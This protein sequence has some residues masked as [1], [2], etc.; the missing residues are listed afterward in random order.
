MKLW[1]KTT[2]V[3]GF[4]VNFRVDQWLDLPGIKNTTRYFWQQGKDLCKIPQ[5]QRS[6][7][8]EEAVVRL[9]LTPELLNLQ[10][11]RYFSLFLFFIVFA[12]GLLAYTAFLV[13]A[14][15]KMGALVSFSLILYTLSLAFRHHFWYFQISRKK[16][17]C[18][19]QE[20]LDSRIVPLEKETV[21]LSRCNK[22][23]QGSL[24]A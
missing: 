18:G 24:S 20:W 17:G 13:I 11:K 23:Q 14:G 12:V 2:K 22:V 8:F 4:V 15:N 3:L 9:G 7:S 21:V 1:K 5:P 6:E 16:L 10:K 19:I